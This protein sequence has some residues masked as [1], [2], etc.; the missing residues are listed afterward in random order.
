MKYTD[1]TKC[2][3]GSGD[4]CSVVRWEGKLD[5]LYLKPIFD[6]QWFAAEDEGRTEEP[7]E[8]KKKKAREDEGRVLKSQEF[9][10][11][12]GL[13]LPALLLLLLAP[14]LF[15]T[16][17]EMIRFF[18]LRVT[19]LDPAKDKLVFV[20][21]V[22]YFIKLALPMLA[23][24]VVAALLSNII[25]VGF[26]W[27]TKHLAFKFDRIVPKFGAYFS[28][29]LFSTQG[30]FNLFKA[31]IKMVI[32]GS[33]A[34][35]LI[36]SDIQKLTNL[37]TVNLFLSFKTIA[38]IA[39]KMLIFTA[40]MLLILAIPDYMFARSQYI[41][42]LKMS[43][44]E[45]VEEHK[46]SEGDPQIKN[47]LR[48]RMRELLNSKVRETVPEA[49]VVITNPDHF[50]VALQYKA[51][52][53]NG[54]IVIMKGEDDIAQRIKAVAREFDI[55]IYENKPLARALYRDVEI[56]DEVPEKYWN[57]ILEI[58]KRVKSM[59]ELHRMLGM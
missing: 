20:Y 30:L 54:P 1:V 7:T 46:E 51:S 25:Q 9:V 44:Q 15:K 18:L 45:V 17:L 27:T 8:L 37:E 10:G 4:F 3:S 19:E 59:D 24:A 56:G 36:R 35:F 52:Q 55:P 29:T 11:A 5:Y 43:K 32:V 57:L 50:A 31:F 47:R 38:G 2:Y 42:S 13:L 53:S 26:L 6:L 28:K 14:Y 34:F 39:I 16:F 33:I 22:R 21:V 41:E 58:L 48:Q 40:I 49:D 12:L 23:V